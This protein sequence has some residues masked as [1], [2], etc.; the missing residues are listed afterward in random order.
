MPGPFAGLKIVDVTSVFVGP[1]CT[2]L[3][4]DMGAE[5]VKV[6]APEGDLTRLTGPNRN[7]GMSSSFLHLNRKSCSPISYATATMSRPAT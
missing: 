4:A 6:E 2:Q 1:F 7:D 5:V 3:L